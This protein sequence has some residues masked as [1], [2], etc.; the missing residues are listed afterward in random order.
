MPGSPG[1]TPGSPTKPGSREPRPRVRWNWP[2][3]SRRATPPPPP[4]SIGVWSHRP[5]LRSSS[6]PAA[7]APRPCAS[8]NAR[9]SKAPWSRRPSDSTPTSFAASPAAIET[10][11]PDQDAVDAHENEQVK[12]QE[13]IARSKTRLTFH[14]NGDGTV[15]GHFTAPTLAASYLRRVIESMTAPRR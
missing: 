10:I 4:H 13:E 14:D 11:E 9:S 5:T 6:T 2:P 7:N 12:T 8:N 3:T 1:P 15:T